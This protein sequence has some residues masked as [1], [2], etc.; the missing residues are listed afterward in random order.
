MQT[1]VAADTDQLV[2]T[3]AAQIRALSREDAAKAIPV[4]LVGVAVSSDSITIDLVDGTS[5]IYSEGDAILKA[6][7]QPGDWVA[8]DGV[9][10]PGKFAP[11]VRATS[12]KKLE[13]QKFRNRKK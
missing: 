10:D 8:L 9:T 3:N 2:L 11:Y 1:T 12:A 7:L 13:R 5:R 6:Q 4:R